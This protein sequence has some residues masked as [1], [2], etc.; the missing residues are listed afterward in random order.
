MKQQIN[1]QKVYEELKKIKKAMI[2]RDEMN[3]FIETVEILSNPETMHQI[4]S[5]KRDI[6]AGYFKEINSVSEL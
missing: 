6:E 3:K 1:L 5:S 4:H 2:T